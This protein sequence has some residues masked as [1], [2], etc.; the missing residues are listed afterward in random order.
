MSSAYQNTLNEALGRQVIGDCD[1]RQGL[2]F[3]IIFQG[4]MCSKRTHRLLA[5]WVICGT[6]LEQTRTIQF[7][8]VYNAVQRL[9]LDSNL[10]K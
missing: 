6:A 7:G 9:K 2:G 10:I 4:N 8:R 5:Y 1:F 3:G